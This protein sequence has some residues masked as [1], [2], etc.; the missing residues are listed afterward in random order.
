MK[1]DEKGNVVKGKVSHYGSA[2]DAAQLKYMKH[3]G[4]DLKQLCNLKDKEYQKILEIPFSSSRKRMS[5]IIQTKDNK[6]L[7]LIKGASEIIL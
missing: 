6:K 5:C 3:C 2:T 4:Y 1:K 7:L